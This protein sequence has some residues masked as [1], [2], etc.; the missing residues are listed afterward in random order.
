MRITIETEEQAPTSVQTVTKPERIMGV[1]PKSGGQS[2]ALQQKVSTSKALPAA[3]RPQRA[4]ARDGG[5]PSALGHEPK[6][7]VR[8]ERS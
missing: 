2:L 7:E 8:G 5:P 6:G 4:G 3:Q 1:A